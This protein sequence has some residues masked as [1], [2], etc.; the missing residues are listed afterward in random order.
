[1]PVMAD[2]DNF[3]ESSYDNALPWTSIKPAPFVAAGDL[4]DIVPLLD[5]KHE[6]RVAKDKDYQ[7]LEED[8]AQVRKVRKD[9]QISLNETVRRKERD[10]E[11]ARTKLREQR[12]LASLAN[13]GDDLVVLPDP[14]DA[15]N[16]AVDARGAGKNAKAIAA[17]KAAMQSDDGLQV[18][19]R[20]L[21]AEL[22]QEQAAK[23]AKDVLLDE[24][25]HIL[26]DEV[27]LLKADSHLAAQVLPYAAP[28]DVRRA[29]R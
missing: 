12:L 8:I 21:A 25:A 26:A 17:V 13:P 28:A 16:K 27:G 23:S 15:L 4:K 9:N 29:A 22:A 3:G 7:Y 10:A 18:D 19:E 6:A 2:S 20:S 24:A 14:K 11:N 1:L 5:K